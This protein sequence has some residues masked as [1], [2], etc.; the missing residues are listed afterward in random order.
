MFGL[1]YDFPNNE[2]GEGLNQIDRASIFLVPSV[3]A[4]AT[5]TVRSAPVSGVFCSV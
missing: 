3:P 4:S 5:A 1:A 2:R